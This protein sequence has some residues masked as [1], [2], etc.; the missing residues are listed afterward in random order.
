MNV[1]SNVA[2]PLPSAPARRARHGPRIRTHKFGGTDRRLTASATD[3]RCACA[4]SSARADHQEAF[5]PT[6]GERLPLSCRYISLDYHR[7]GGK[8]HSGS[9]IMQSPARSRAFSVSS[10]PQTSWKF[11]AAGT[12]SIASAR[13]G[14]SR[15][16]KCPLPIGTVSTG[17]S[18]SVVA[19]SLQVQLHVFF[20]V[21]FLQQHPDSPASAYASTRISND[22]STMRK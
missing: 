2:E 20:R 15:L 4:L 12:G 8:S 18:I 19:A 11:T 7:G 3:P 1:S 21:L 10:L 5:W 9:A 14:R 17:L 13:L 22:S 16:Y 6:R